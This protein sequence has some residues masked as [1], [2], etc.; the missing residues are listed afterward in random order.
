MNRNCLLRPATLD[1][2]VLIFE[3]RNQDR[4]RNM[5][6]NKDKIAWDD[7]RSRFNLALRAEQHMFFVFEFASKPVGIVQFS[8]F[9]GENRRCHWGYYMGFDPAPENAAKQMAFCAC[10]HIFETLLYERLVADVLEFNERSQR[11]L[12]GCGFSCDGILRH[13]IRGPGVWHDVHRFSILR[14]EWLAQKA[15]F[16]ERIGIDADR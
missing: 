15:A 12:R 8:Q 13:E 6:F 7:H 3:W 16:G 5:M 2:S 1:D 14:A 4:V 11:Y 9:D 10:E